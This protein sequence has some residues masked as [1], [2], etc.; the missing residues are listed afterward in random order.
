MDESLADK[1]RSLGV[2]LGAQNIPRPSKREPSGFPIE[3][4]LEG[5]EQPTPYGPVFEMIHDFGLD[6]RHGIIGFD[7]HLKYRA[8]SRWA[9]LSPIR[10]VPGGSEN[11]EL[12]LDQLVFLDTETSGLA[13]GTGTY[14]FLVGLGFFDHH[15][16]H[17]L[18][19]FLRDPASEEAFLSAIIQSLLGFQG[20]V[21]FN[22]KSFD[23][24]L[25]N[26]RFVLN[27]IATPFAGLPHI[28][29][30]GLARRLWRNRLS[31][32]AL[33]DLETE[34]LQFSR[35]MDEVPGWMIP[36]IYFEYMRTGDARPMA[37]VFYHNAMDIVSLF[38][39]F[40]FCA[41][42]LENPLGD[43]AAPGLDLVAA[44]RLYE[45]QDNI[46]LA[47]QIYQQSL[48]QGDLPLHFYL[49]TV[50]RF[51]VLY[52][53]MGNWKQAVHLWKTAAA[54]D[55]L[56]SIIEL[57]KYHEHQERDYST[58]RSYLQQARTLLARMELPAWQKKSQESDLLHRLERIE[59]KALGHSS[60]TEK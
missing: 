15:G 2:Q 48:I 31:S 25:L 12:L 54:F 3:A 5:R 8:I 50:H 6:Y 7:P 32:R 20:I 38:A 43:L 45:E 4:V 33:K 44:A 27:Q 9:K 21:S 56:E 36:E 14:V 53:K 60:K 42:F 47:I 19:I 35:T 23:I 13:G 46:D 41:N 22:G 37:G 24:P 39:L 11:A 49:D 59:K 17:V 26:A 55:D 28:D 18:Q 51:A 30:L 34:I 58:A 52:R 16:F 29:L 10:D 40:H 57:S 1:L